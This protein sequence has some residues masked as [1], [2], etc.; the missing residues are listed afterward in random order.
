MF[1]LGTR[2]LQRILLVILTRALLMMSSH[3]ADWGS[4]GWRTAH[5]PP[6]PALLDACDELGYVVWDENHRNGQFDQVPWLIKRDRN[7]P[8]I[9]IWCGCCSCLSPLPVLFLPSCFPLLPLLL[10]STPVSCLSEFALL[11][12]LLLHLLDICIL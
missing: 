1:C 12:L 9:V 8:S 6:T 10:P 3:S 4:N 11:L 2:S 5:N 7:H